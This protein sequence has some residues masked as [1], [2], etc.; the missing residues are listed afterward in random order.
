MKKRSTCSGVIPIPVAY[1]G[2]WVFGDRCEIGINV[3]D[4]FRGGESALLFGQ[5][6]RVYR[7]HYRVRR[8]LVDPFQ[9]GAGNRE[10]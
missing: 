4:D 9:F 5:I 2:G 10:G 8:F 1:G 6:L 3:F 7:H